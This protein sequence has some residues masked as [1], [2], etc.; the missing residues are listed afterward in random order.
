MLT[1]D[2]YIFRYLLFMYQLLK[3]DDHVRSAGIPPSQATQVTDTVAFD[4]CSLLA[5][6]KEACKG[7]LR[8]CFFEPDVF[9][10]P[11]SWPVPSKPENDPALDGPTNSKAGPFNGSLQILK[12]FEFVRVFKEE[13][14][15]VNDCLVIGGIRWIRALKDEKDAKSGLWYRDK[16]TYITWEGRREE[17]SEWLQIPEYR[18]GDLVYIWKAI[19]SLEAMVQESKRDGRNAENIQE[20]SRTL[21][22]SK[23]RHRDVRA[24]VLKRFLSQVPGPRPRKEVDRNEQMLDGK[25][26]GEPDAKASSF[27]IPVR[28]SREKDRLLFYSKDTMLHD[29]IQ[30]GFFENDIEVEA[31][32]AN[33]EPVKPEIKLSMENTMRAQGEDQEVVWKKPL[34]YALAIIMAG[35]NHPLDNS[36]SPAELEKVSWDRLLECVLP[37]GIIPSHIHW[38]T[39]Q[40]RFL[41]FSGDLRSTWEIPTLLLRCRFNN[42][43]LDVYV[44]SAYATFCAILRI[45]IHNDSPITGARTDHPLPLSTYLSPRSSKVMPIKS[46][47]PSSWPAT[48]SPKKRKLR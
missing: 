14:E 6:I 48:K 17:G 22:E 2:S 38:D 40:P 43:E 41:D 18:L 29:G 26:A 15:L 24:T 12:L 33:N 44:S 46:Q 42:L 25:A 30:W 28:R 5:R 47:R 8:W 20:I 19:K 1:R 10:A 7:H 45:R 36:K 27:V 16:R 23:L 3:P 13:A 32:N 4:K 39:K 9:L 11:Q 21:R 34:H 35:Y 37:H 31:T